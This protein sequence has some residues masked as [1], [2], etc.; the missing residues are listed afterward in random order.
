MRAAGVLPSLRLLIKD[1]GTKGRK[2]KRISLVLVLCAAL[3]AM[4]ATGASAA[5]GAETQVKIDGAT[6][7]SSGYIV[8]G[9]L[10]SESDKC[11]AKRKVSF[12]TKPASGP[13]VVADT[14]TSTANGAWSILLL[15][16]PPMGDFSIDVKKKTLKSG[17]VCKGVSEPF[18]P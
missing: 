3:M 11:T 12:V 15:S 16:K 2:M 14:G 1:G 4:V 5:P 17:L 9:V 10:H 13:D 18:I 7:V 6:G 8:F